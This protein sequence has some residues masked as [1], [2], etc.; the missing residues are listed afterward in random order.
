[1]I[2]NKFNYIAT[3]DADIKLFNDLLQKTLNSSY[4]NNK[5]IHL[6]QNVIKV[7][8]KYKSRKQSLNGK[9]NLEKNSFKVFSEDELFLYVYKYLYDQAYLRLF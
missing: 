9:I 6:D 8:T 2:V 7:L 3:N 1:M 5:L 4:F